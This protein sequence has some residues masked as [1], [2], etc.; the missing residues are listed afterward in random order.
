MFCGL[1][2]DEDNQGEMTDERV[3]EW[4]KQIMSEV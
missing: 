3:E 1:S 2:L 4:C